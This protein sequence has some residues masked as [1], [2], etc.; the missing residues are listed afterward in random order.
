M[1]LVPVAL[2]PEAVPVAPVLEAPLRELEVPVPLVPVAEPVAAVEPVALLP[3]LVPVPAPV[4]ADEEDLP[5]EEE[6]VEPV[7][8]PLATL[9]PPAELVPFVELEPEVL[10]VLAFA[11]ALVPVCTCVSLGTS[12]TLMVLLKSTW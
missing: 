6:E 8:E 5:R 1:R 3:V 7:P 9:L 4:L 12:S 10:V 11:L 2:W